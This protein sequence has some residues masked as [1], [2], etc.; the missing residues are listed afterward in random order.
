MSYSYIGNETNNEEKILIGQLN[1]LFIKHYIYNVCD[2][3]IIIVEELNQSELERLYN[4]KYFFKGKKL[5]IV[6]NMKKLNQKEFI[7]YVEKISREE[8][9]CEKIKIIDIEGK[10]INNYIYLENL[11]DE[12]EDNIRKTVIIKENNN[13]NND[14]KENKE[15]IHLF[16]GND[17]I[18]DIKKY[19]EEI[20][21]YI[22]KQIET[23][24]MQN[25][26]TNEKFCFE[27]IL[28]FNLNSF[29]KNYLLIKHIHTKGKDFSVNSL[30]EIAKKEKNNIALDIIKEEN[31]IKYVIK[32]IGN[33]NVSVIP[34]NI[35]INFYTGGSIS[36]DTLN[37]EN[38]SMYFDDNFH[39]L[40]YKQ[41]FMDINK[42]NCSIHIKDNFL[43]ESNEYI[44][45]FIKI[46]GE[47]EN[48]NEKNSYKSTR[49][50]K[51]NEIN[52]YKRFEIN[53]RFQRRFELYNGD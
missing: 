42:I 15:I 49:V 4:L 43:E 47:I 28:K 23:N 36:N 34:K 22:I 44:T 27:K 48:Y 7:N 11:K 10:N 1:E 40:F 50:Y 8:F 12:E 26:N 6:H 38:V 20:F 19:N 29:S 31:L 51:L 18:D 3:I 33:D 45:Y 2:L 39:I 30:N 37:I 17:N 14:K 21:S 25:I 32:S 46:E 16:I 53:M 5:I 41:S 35:N 24:L 13:N 52:K 9:K